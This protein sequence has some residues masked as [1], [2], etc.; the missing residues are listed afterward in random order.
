MGYTHYWDFKQ[1]KGQAKINETNYQKA[2]GQCNK[3][4]KGYNAAVKA[5]DLKHG[6]R[7]SGFSAYAKG[8]GGLEVN[9]TGEEGHETFVLRE[10][11]NQNTSDFCKTAQKPYDVVVVAC[12]I[13][14]KH[15][16][17]EAFIVD[18]D[19]SRPDWIDG[20]DLA[21]KYTGLKSLKI[22]AT[23]RSR[24]SIVS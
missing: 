4:I 13:I 5:I 17:D 18:S 24:L 9:G 10:H 7:L 22:P 21:Q 14:L 2:I 23:I 20:L 8:Y 3:I 12:L 15:Y 6:A 1:V 16:L 11:F 19:G